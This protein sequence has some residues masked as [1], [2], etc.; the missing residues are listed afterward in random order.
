M[1]TPINQLLAGG[2]AGGMQSSAAPSTSPQPGQQGAMPSDPTMSQQPQ[3]DLA[4]LAAIRDE[5]LRMR[6]ESPA[7]APYIDAAIQALVDGLS[8]TMQGSEGAEGQQ[9]QMSSQAQQP[10]MTQGDSSYQPSGYSQM[11][12]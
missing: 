5:L 8:T 12:Y 7:M 10:M 6:S 2:M 11:P 4:K 1:A 3:P 9:G